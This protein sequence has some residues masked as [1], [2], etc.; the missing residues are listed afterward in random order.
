MAAILESTEI[1]KIW[2]VFNTSQKR[3]EE[4]YGIFVYEDQNGYMR[5]AIEKKRKYNNPICTFHY[6]V[7]CHG[8]LRKLVKEFSL[9]PKLCFI[10]T[11]NEKCIGILEEYCYGACEK[12]EPHGIYNERVLQ[13]IASLTHRP[14]YI[15]LDKGLTEEENSCIMVVKGSFFGMGYLPKNIQELTQKSIKEYINPYNENS[16][17]RTLFHFHANNFPEQVKLLNG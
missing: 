16:F 6:K 15:V 7:D 1:K 11:D 2:P 13:A 4:V 10:Q 12:S 17:I 9:C 14:S 8:V 3:Q 5:L